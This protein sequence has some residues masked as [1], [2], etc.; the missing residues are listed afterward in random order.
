[1]NLKQ[2]IS[3]SIC[4][5]LLA[6]LSQ[7]S[8]PFPFTA[9]PATLQIVAITIISVIFSEKLGTL[10]VCIYILLGAI[11]LPVFSGFKGGLNT[12]VGP[13]GGYI[14]GFILFSFFTGLGSKKSNIIS[15]YLFSYLG[16][17]LDY[18]LGTIQLK[19]NL[20]LTF[21][22]AFLSGVAPFIIKDII[23]ISVAIPVGFKLRKILKRNSILV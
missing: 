17:M 11:G 21:Y 20:N 4:A 10:S 8:I 3:V 22:A 16:L 9:V 23:L 15:P 5:A 13:T 2:K 12:I 18:T 1:M 14:I 6:V 19:Y 7:V